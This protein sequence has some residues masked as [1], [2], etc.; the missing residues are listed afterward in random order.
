M[1]CRQMRISAAQ[2]EH[3]QGVLVLLCDDMLSPLA[4][5]LRSQNSCP[6][7]FSK[8]NAELR[9]RCDAAFME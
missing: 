8:R 6:S 2:P 3:A 4:L 1:A 5:W 9:L 7:K